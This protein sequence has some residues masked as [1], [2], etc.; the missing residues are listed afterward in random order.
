MLKD[1]KPFSYNSRL[2]LSYLGET[3]IELIQN[4]EGE[5]VFTE[6]VRDHGYGLHHCG[7]YVPD[8]EASLAEAR[9]CGIRVLQEGGGFGPDGD[10]YFAYLDTH[11]MFGITYEIIERPKRRYEPDSIYPAS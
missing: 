6:F 5:T 10:G 11:K 1:G 9:A 3:R 2:A 8:I 7:I 4:L